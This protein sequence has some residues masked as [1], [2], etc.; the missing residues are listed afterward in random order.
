[1]CGFLCVTNTL[2]F[3]NQDIL[4]SLKLIHHRGPDN[5]QYHINFESELNDII[6]KI[7]F[8]HSSKILNIDKKIIKENLM[9]S[10]GSESHRAR[11]GLIST[12]LLGM[13]YID[14]L[15]K[16]NVYEIIK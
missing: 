15:D 12:E 5:C 11:Y 1:M 6:Q 7:D 9:I 10:L 4:N 16:K 13:M 3:Q 8:V 14:K 2:N